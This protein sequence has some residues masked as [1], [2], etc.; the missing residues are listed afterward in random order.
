MPPQPVEVDVASKKRFEPVW[1]VEL[2]SLVGLNLSD[3]LLG[4]MAA[5]KYG[6]D[7]YFQ[8]KTVNV[9]YA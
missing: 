8:K 1:L 4:L 7:G 9:S 3:V 2:A 5:G 6:L